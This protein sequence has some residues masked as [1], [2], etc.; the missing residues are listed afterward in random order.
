MKT[1]PSQKPKKKKK[2]LDRPELSE[3]R[4]KNNRT[5]GQT[6]KPDAYSHVSCRQLDH[7]FIRKNNDIPFHIL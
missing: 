4:E 2:K 1:S 7:N 6:I 3:T 5:K